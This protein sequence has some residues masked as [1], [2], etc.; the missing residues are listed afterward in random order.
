MS[1]ISIAIKDLFCTDL[2]TKPISN[3][4][5]ILITGASGYIGGR[6]VRELNA[7]GYSIRLMV[8]GDSE[9]YRE[10]WPGLE[11]IDCDALDPAKVDDALKDIDTVYYLIHSLYLGPNEFEAADIKAARNF[12]ILAEKNNVKRIIYLGGMGDKSNP[13]SAHLRNRL[14]V[15][16]ELKKSKVPVTIL[17]AAIIIGS[18]SASYEIIKNLVNRLPVIPCPHW[19]KS[20]CQPISIRDAVKYL[21]G[22][23]EVPETTGG[24]F[25]IGGDDI[26]TYEEMLKELSLVLG[27]KTTVIR[28]PISNTAFYG[29]IVSLITPVPKNITVCLMEGLIN[30]VVCQNRDIG[31][32]LKFKPLSYRESIVKALSREEQDQ[33][34]SRWSDA[35]PPAHE[36]ALK[37]RELNSHPTYTTEYSLDTEKTSASLFT[38]MCRVGGREGWFDNTWMWKARGMIDRI[39]MGVGTSRGRKSYSS[40]RINDVI[41]FWRVE[42]IITNQRL[43]L[44]AEMKIPGRAWLE[45]K[46]NHQA[47]K[48]VISVVPYYYTNSIIGKLYWF[49]FLPFHHFIFKHL[50]EEIERRC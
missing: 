12:R 28:S 38:A 32:F 29:Y 4:G 3:Y 18:G 46:I 9:D 14:E 33:V 7:R 42:D 24:D 34:H 1:R 44:R 27:K 10:Q 36:L 26:F 23:L 39:L 45:L 5:K 31:Q 40:L 25:C 17:R 8:R 37:L 47:N 20:K 50:L 13:M 19:T 48:N 43:L 2:P 16:Q 35:Y 11:I 15:A 6:L 30:D 22:V 21:V 49:M 41:D